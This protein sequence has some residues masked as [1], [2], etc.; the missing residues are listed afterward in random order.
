MSCH[1]AGDE[2]HREARRMPSAGPGG[3]SNAAASVLRQAARGSVDSSTNTAALWPAALFRKAVL[4]AGS[5][6]RRGLPG[7][8]MLSGHKDHP[9]SVVATPPASEGRSDLGIL[10][11]GRATPLRMIRTYVTI[12]GWHGPWS[13]GHR[14]RTSSA[15]GQSG[16]LILPA[17]SRSEMV[18][19]VAG[20]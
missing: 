2:Q 3:A 10:Q 17:A 13:S 4:P 5:F 18:A 19:P 7:N 20:P 8:A 12:G 1:I 16:K 14:R 15:L 6:E 11:P 9:V